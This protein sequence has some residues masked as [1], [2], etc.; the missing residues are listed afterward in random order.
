ME[1]EDKITR[2]KK[3]GGKKRR[4]ETKDKMGRYI[5]LP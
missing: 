5:P 4:E 3:R 2:G 1:K